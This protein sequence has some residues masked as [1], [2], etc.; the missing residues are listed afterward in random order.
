MRKNALLLLYTQNKVKGSPIIVT[1]KNI[2][3]GYAQAVIVN[4][5]NAN[6]CNADGE[7]KA[8]MMCDMTAKELE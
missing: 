3:D 6:T 8:Q 5:T 4:S 1:Q 2:A 7:E